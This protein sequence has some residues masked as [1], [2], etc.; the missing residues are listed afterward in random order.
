MGM[1]MSCRILRIPSKT[2][3][4][5]LQMSQSSVFLPSAWEKNQP[6]PLQQGHCIM[7]QSSITV[8]IENHSAVKSPLAF[9]CA[10]LVTREARPCAPPA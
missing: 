2:R 8:L 1:K 7:A 5:P 9:L 4:L 6:S 10:C 3:P